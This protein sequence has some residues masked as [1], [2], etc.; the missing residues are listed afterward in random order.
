MRRHKYYREKPDGTLHV[1]IVKATQGPYSRKRPAAADAALAKVGFRKTKKPHTV[2][3]PHPNRR[4]I[5]RLRH[6]A[7]NPGRG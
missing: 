2:A 1:D 6:A 4:Y 3:S 5:A 7:Q